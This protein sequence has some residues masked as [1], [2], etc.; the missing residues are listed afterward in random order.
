MK[1]L[2]ACLVSGCRCP[3]LCMLAAHGHGDHWRSL[4][5]ADRAAARAQGGLAKE[6]GRWAEG[7][8]LELVPTEVPGLDPEHEADG[9]HEVGFAWRW[10]GGKVQGVCA[11]SDVSRAGG[12]GEG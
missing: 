8:Y 12:E 6:S 2:G 3:P 5:E 4:G 9:I 11:V 10:G 1:G 7:G